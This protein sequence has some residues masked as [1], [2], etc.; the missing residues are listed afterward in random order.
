[1]RKS[2]LR[3]AETVEAGENLLDAGHGIAAG[4]AGTFCKEREPFFV[5]LVIQ[6]AD[7]FPEG[8]LSVNQAFGCVFQKQS[9]GCGLFA[10]YNLLN[11]SKIDFLPVQRE[12]IFSMNFCFQRVRRAGFVMIRVLWGRW[13]AGVIELARGYSIHNF[14]T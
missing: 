13:N 1:M 12:T 9:K 11:I 10:V 7:N 2:L 5:K 3:S 6:V 8:P 4:N 14:L